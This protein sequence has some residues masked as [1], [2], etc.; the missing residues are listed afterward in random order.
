MERSMR[1]DVYFHGDL[2]ENHKLDRV[3][4]KLEELKVLGERIMA[5]ELEMKSA[6]DKI[7]VATTKIGANLTV[8]SGVVTTIGEDVDALIAALQAAGIPQELIDQATS[9]G[10]KSEAAVAALDALV[11]V[12]QAIASKGVINPVPVPVPPVPKPPVNP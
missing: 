4:G 2:V 3:L 11:P 12:L 8:V 9:I 7:D 1:V 5:T 6:L 10:T